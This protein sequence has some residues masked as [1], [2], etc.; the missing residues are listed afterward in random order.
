[1]ARGKS[2]V[3]S[4]DLACVE[5]GVSSTKVYKVLQE[6]PDLKKDYEGSLQLLTDCFNVAWSLLIYQ[7]HKRSKEYDNQ[8]KAKRKEN[9]TAA[10]VR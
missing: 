1:M 5:A 10:N 4:F 3:N 8:E 7:I 9:E 6:N 2:S